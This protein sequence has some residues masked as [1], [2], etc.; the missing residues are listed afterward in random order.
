MSRNAPCR[1]SARS[2]SIRNSR[3]R[4]LRHEQLEDRRVLSGVEISIDDVTAIEGDDTGVFV[5]QF[6]PAPGLAGAL[7]FISDFVVGTDEN[8]YVA[9][10]DTDE[11]LR[12][13]QATGDL[14][15]VFVP[16]GSGGLSGPR[17]LSFGLDGLLYVGSYNSDEVLR[18]NGTTGEYVD[19]FPTGGMISQ[20]D[21]LTFA[22]DGTTL[23][24][25][26]VG[27][28]EVL[29]YDVTNGTFLGVVVSA[30]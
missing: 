24:V 13:D 27:T 26:N 22:D 1:R 12:Y 17:G 10:R 8:I 19:T 25:A 4:Q 16:A 7:E 29:S 9:S 20:P 23:Y 5:D 11:I 15:D 3:F 28:N 18:F 21:A 2:Q 6:L 14:I 30:S